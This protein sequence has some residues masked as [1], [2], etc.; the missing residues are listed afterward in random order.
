MARLFRG[1]QAQTTTHT[2]RT[3]CEVRDLLLTL[4]RYRI[5]LYGDTTHDAGYMERVLCL[6][7]PVLPRDQ[8][9]Q[10]SSEAARHGRAEVLICPREPAEYYCQCLREWRLACS[11][12]LV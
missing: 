2:Q 6:T 11:L 7:I 4:P 3:E 10:V 5:L 12:E 9:R 1:Q 8:A